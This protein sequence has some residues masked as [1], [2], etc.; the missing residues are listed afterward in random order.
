MIRTI[1]G[2][3]V[4]RPSPGERRGSR[5]RLSRNLPIVALRMPCRKDERLNNPAHR[6][7]TIA[8]IGEHQTAI[9]TATAIAKK[10]ADCP[11]GTSRPRRSTFDPPTPDGAPAEGRTRC[12]RR[13]ARPR[14][15]RACRGRRVSPVWRWLRNDDRTRYGG[16]HGRS[17]LPS[18]GLGAVC[19]VEVVA[20]DAVG[21]GRLEGEMVERVAILRMFSPVREVA[22]ACR[23]QWH[24]CV[25]RTRKEHPNG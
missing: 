2:R 24:Q 21:E 6:G 1:I 7:T 25:V 18:S 16:R 22:D 14:R 23:I 13:S 17:R 10:A 5:L 20:F 19:A 4:H 15:S 8:G 11:R 3:R 12:S 9:G